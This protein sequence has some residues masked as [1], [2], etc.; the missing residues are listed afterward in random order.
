MQITYA[1]MTSG[2]KENYSCGEHVL[3]RVSNP[4][5]EGGLP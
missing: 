5:H 1:I 3:M 4:G 2:I